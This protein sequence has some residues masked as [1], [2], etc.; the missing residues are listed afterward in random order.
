V[1]RLF[2]EA[3]LFPRYASYLKKIRYPASILAFVLRGERRQ[4][5]Q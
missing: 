4:L 1:F 2:F 5:P 3:H